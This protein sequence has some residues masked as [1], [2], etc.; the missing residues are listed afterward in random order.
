MYTG[1]PRGLTTKADRNYRMVYILMKS[2]NFRCLGVYSLPTYSSREK[3][4]R[5]LACDI[6]GN[7]L[8]LKEQLKLCGELRRMSLKI[9]TQICTDILLNTKICRHR[10]NNQWPKFKKQQL[11]TEQNKMLYNLKNEIFKNVS[12]SKVSLWQN[13]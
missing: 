12:P 8:L 10:G 13:N 11:E 3:S 9:L 4:G 6:G 7:N 5:F 1:D 2:V